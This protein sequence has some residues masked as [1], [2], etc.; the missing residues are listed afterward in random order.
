MAVSTTNTTD[1]IEIRLAAYHN[2]DDVQL[3]WR[4]AVGGEEDMPVPD[5][6]GYMIERRRLGP[7]GQWLPTE[8]LRNRVSFSGEKDEGEDTPAYQTQP[9]NVWPFQRYDWTDH[10][11]NNG[12]AVRYRVAAVVLPDG[13]TIGESELHAIADSGWTEPIIVVGET[14]GGVSAYFNRG[15]VMSQYV[16]R[17]ARKNGWGPLDLKAHIKELEEPLRLFL[18][19]ELRLAMLRLLDEVIGDDSLAFYCALYELD[20]VELIGRLTTLGGRAH[21]VLSNGSDK[22]GD[23]NERARSALKDA[24]VDVRDRLLGNQGLG[25]N[26]FAVVAD[27]AGE[28][29]SHAWTGSTNWA[30]TGLC[31]Q[32]NNGILFEDAEVAQ[33]YLEQWHRLADAKSGFTTGFVEANAESPRVAGAAEVWFTRVRNPSMK[34]D[35][36]PGKDI[37]ALI[38]LV[39]GAR[40]M[41]LYVMFQPGP[42]PLRSIIERAEEDGMIVKG[43]VSTAPQSIT[44]EEFELVGTGTHKKYKTAMV[45]PEGV[46]QS[47]SAWVKEVTCDEFLTTPHHEGVGHAITHSKMIVMDPLSDDCLVIT[48]SHNFSKAASEHNDENFVVVRGNRALAEAY[49][50]ACLSTY[51]HYRWRAY[52]KDKA[53]AG[54]AIWDHLSGG[55]EWQQECLTPAVKQTLSA[56]CP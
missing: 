41:I 16:A 46:G 32:A 30:A 44:E 1:G 45:Q 52:V 51:A 22:A 14:D 5:C 40:E 33:L 6:L 21:V 19:G 53:E 7:D 8:V 4:A 43:V 23:G 31:T 9:S 27:A 37:Q 18:S 24:G 29:A 39:N 36:P 3:F 35:I 48:G 54:E 34:K 20:D 2:C 38:D 12:Q 17:I 47:F 11:A 50:V 25:H 42:E 26:K 49:S 55:P 28:S 56:W 13:G 15:F 10:G